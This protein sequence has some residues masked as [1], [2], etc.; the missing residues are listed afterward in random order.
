VDEQG[1]TTLGFRV[2]LAVLARGAG[3]CDSKSAAFC[4]LWRQVP[5]R[6]VLVMVPN[7]AL[8][9]VEARPGPDQASIRLGNRTYVLCE[10]AGPAR[11]PPG[12]TDQSGSF[13]YV[14][15]EPATAPL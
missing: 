3:D 7:H 11:L 14:V 8:V 10:V 6:V 4:A 9:A 2:P 12:R 13:E 1:R 5:A 15:I